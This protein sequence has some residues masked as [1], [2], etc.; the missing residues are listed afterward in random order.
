M[1]YFEWLPKEYEYLIRINNKETG[2]ILEQ[3]FAS[4]G[5]AEIYENMLDF[6]GTE[7]EVYSRESTGNWERIQ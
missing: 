5:D 7:Y 1:N 2:E 4:C 3:A 6:C